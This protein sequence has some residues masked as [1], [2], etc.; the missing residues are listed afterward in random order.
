MIL[1]SRCVF[2]RIHIMVPSRRRYHS[3]LS[4]SLVKG[5]TSSIVI[6]PYIRMLRQTCAP[7]PL[8]QHQITEFLSDSAAQFRYPILPPSFGRTVLSV[9]SFAKKQN[10][11]TPKYYQVSYINSRAPS[12]EKPFCFSFFSS[13]DVV[14]MFR[15]NFP[16]LIPRECGDDGL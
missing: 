8:L 2:S 14:G 9:F 10:I 1:V 12:L 16:V 15:L 7:F 4:P 11:Y 3:C 13:P 5:R 6:P